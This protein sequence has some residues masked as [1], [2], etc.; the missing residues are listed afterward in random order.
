MPLRKIRVWNPAPHLKVRGKKK[1][2]KKN[3]LTEMLVSDLYGAA[4]KQ[5]SK[6]G[7]RKK[8]GSSKRKSGNPYVAIVGLDE[9]MKKKKNPQ[10]SAL[11]KYWAARK[12]Q[13]KK[14]RKA[15]SH[16]T[17]QR[18]GNPMAKSKKKKKPN[19]SRA[20]Y[21]ISMARSKGGN[22]YA[23]GRSKPRKRNPNISSLFGALKPMDLIYLGAGVVAGSVAVRLVPQLALGDKNQGTLGHVANIGTGVIGAGLVAA[24]NKPAGFGFAAGALGSYLTR[25]IDDVTLKVQGFLPGAGTA[26]LKGDRMFNGLGEY[27]KRAYKIDDW[28]LQ[29]QQQASLQALNSGRMRLVR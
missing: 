8:K 19:P 23:K 27:N 25:V 2:H 18:S 20:G 11:R 9:T 5:L 12:R 4:K 21:G 10:P 28:V 26:G 3:L 14:K 29:Q 6:L 24:A 16:S 13:D 17:S 15:N 22:A 1:P 7:R